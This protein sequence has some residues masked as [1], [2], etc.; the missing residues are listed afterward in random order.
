MV[1]NSLM[2]M[3]SVTMS[4]TAIKRLQSSLERVIDVLLGLILDLM[5]KEY[6]YNLYHVYP[7]LCLPDMGRKFFFWLSGLYVYYMTR[8]GPN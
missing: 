1:T 2:R 4:A 5:L 6:V 3:T 7:L 8:R